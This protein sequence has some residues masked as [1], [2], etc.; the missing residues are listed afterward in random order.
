[1][2]TKPLKKKKLLVKKCHFQ[3]PK[4][5]Y[6]SK[7]SCSYDAIADDNPLCVFHI[8][9]PKISSQYPPQDIE[10]KLIEEK[11]RNQIVEILSNVTTSK[12]EFIDFRGVQF[13]QIEFLEIPFSKTVDFSYAVFNEDVDFSIEIPNPKPE[14]EY[15]THRALLLKSGGVF[16]QTV[17][18]KEAKFSGCEIDTEINFENAVFEGDALFAGLNCKG[19]GNFNEVNFNSEVNFENCDFKDIGFSNANFVKSVDFSD[20]RVGFSASFLG[21]TFQQNV[22]FW[23]TGFGNTYIEENEIQESEL[24]GYTSF[25]N[26]NFQGTFVFS[27][28]HLNN[29]ISFNSATFTKQAEFSGSKS[30]IFSDGCDFCGV[31]LPKEEEIV[32]EKVDLSKT[33]FHDTNLEKI[34]FRDVYWGTAK[35][36]L[37]RLFR[38]RSYILWDEIRPMEGIYD[39][40]DESKTAE[41]Y[42]QLV[43]NYE[44][45]RDYES[46]EYFHIGEMEMRRKKVGDEKFQDY[47]KKP[48]KIKDFIW[49]KLKFYKTS[50]FWYELRKYLNGY[51][52]YWLSSRYGTSY[53]QAI[54]VLL[55]LV[56][57]YSFMFLFTGFKSSKENE[58][59]PS[60]L[61]EYNLFPDS[62]HI[63]PTVSGFIR[64]YNEAVS[65]TL[66]IVTFQKERFYEPLSLESRLTLYL[67]VITLTA[68]SALVLLAI[69]RKF[70]R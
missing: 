44:S 62:N 58:E 42:R 51:S 11:F 68:Q 35:S 16:K 47:D 37:Q 54:I 43:L 65:Y 17:F 8:N 27:E 2:K 61:I 28:V 25:D 45:K 70:K 9:K 52:L 5:T 64:D 24:A 36:R 14:H 56:S 4:D 67:A 40:S 22:V 48:S 23:R 12:S 29:E 3:I 57:F 10:A 18:K 30:S 32:F 55:L 66:S 7:Y 59:K 6:E 34:V 38:G 63:T 15:D 21:A 60:R 41:N 46:A 33:S 1:M 39:W 31:T 19:F 49:L 69:R 53:A 13:P 26:V 20:F 50:L